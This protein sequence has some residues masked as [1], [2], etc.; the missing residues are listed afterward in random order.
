MFEF[1]CLAGIAREGIGLGGELFIVGVLVIAHVG[2]VRA[3]VAEQFLGGYAQHVLGGLLIADV[4]FNADL[5]CIKE[6]Q[7][8]VQLY[9]EFGVGVDALD[10]I[11][12]PFPF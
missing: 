11:A 5:Q 1:L 8:V 12:G 6:V 10:D 4:V 7:H 9:H 3:E 2:Y